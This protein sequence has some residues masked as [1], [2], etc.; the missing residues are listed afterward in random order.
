MSTRSQ[1][2]FFRDENVGDLQKFDALIYRHSDGYPDG[3][4]P[5]LM[6]FLRWF[7]RKRGVSDTEYV[8]ARTLQH[9]TNLYDS[10]TGKTGADDFT[11]VLGYGI[12][13]AYH[14]DIEWLYVVTPTRVLVYQINSTTTADDP[15]GWGWEVAKEFIIK[16]DDTDYTSWH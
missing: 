3:V 7:D 9:L 2:A 14:G 13:K 16:D 15:N 11:G 10:A 5:E 8:A 12:S 6:A 4:L 1:I